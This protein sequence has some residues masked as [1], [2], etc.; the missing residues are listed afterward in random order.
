MSV[1]YPIFPGFKPGHSTIAPPMPIRAPKWNYKESLNWENYPQRSVSGRTT[2]TKYWSNPLRNFEWTYGY[3]VDNPLNPNSFYAQTD[4][5]VVPNTD[6][7][8]LKAFYNGMQGTGNQFAFTPPYY[9]VGGTWKIG[10]ITFA[11]ASVTFTGLPAGTAVALASSVGLPLLVL[12]SASSAI[13]GLYLTILS[14]NTGSNT[15]TCAYSGGS[16]SVGAAGVITFGAVLQNPDANNNVELTYTSGSYPNLSGESY[17]GSVVTVVES[18]Q[19][20]DT[21]TLVV[22]DGN[23]NNINGDYTLAAPNSITPPLVY[24]PYVGYVLQFGSNTITP[25]ITATYSLYYL[26]RFSEDTQQF[27]NFLTMLWMAS[28]IKWQQERI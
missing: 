11:A 7:E 22:Y 21:S 10:G 6:F 9:K 5:A 17:A 3:I 28:T 4:L 25:P 18:V 2:V 24:A 12:N 14:V 8:M 16:G 13:N 15:V 20:I 19:L 1:G 27:E 23:G 26:C